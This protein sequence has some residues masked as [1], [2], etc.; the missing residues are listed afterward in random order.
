MRGGRGR[1]PCKKKKKKKKKKE[2]SFFLILILI[3]ILSR[4]QVHFYFKP[5]ADSSQEA[6][7]HR[8]SIA[9]NIN[10]HK[11]VYELSIPEALEFLRDI[12]CVLNFPD[13]ASLPIGEEVIRKGERLLGIIGHEGHGVPLLSGFFV[14]RAAH[15]GQ[16]NEKLEVGGKVINRYI[17]L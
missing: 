14:E 16:V 2:L 1:N 8:L 3:L 5:L 6:A 11:P 12:L 10:Y 9:R 15:S 7:M 17:L 13:Y 4:V